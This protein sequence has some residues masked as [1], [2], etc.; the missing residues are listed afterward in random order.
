MVNIIVCLFT[1][2]IKTQKAQTSVDYSPIEV[3][4]LPT[5]SNKQQETYAGMKT[6]YTNERC[7]MDTIIPIGIY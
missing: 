6:H 3:L 1:M 7:S 5:Q 4:A 2:G